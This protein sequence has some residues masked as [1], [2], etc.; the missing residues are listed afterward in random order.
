MIIAIASSALTILLVGGFTY[1]NQR[2]KRRIAIQQTE[3]EKQRADNLMKNQELATIDAMISGQEKERKK[4]AQDLH[5]DLGSS[6]TTIR[7]Y[8]ENLKDHFKAGTSSEIY[9]RTDKLLEDTYKTIR[10]MSHSRHNGVLASKGLI[11]SMETLGKNLTDSGK[12]RVNIYHNGMDR[13]LENSLEL[14]IFRMLQELLNNVVKHAEAS[15]ATINVIGTDTN[16]SLMVEDDGKGFIKTQNKKSNGLG[17][18]SIE[19]R[20]EE[21]GGTFEV[22]SS[23]GNGTTISIEI[24]II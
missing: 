13:K 21:M 17:L 23:P 22:D 11:P 12:L 4:I 24:P 18:Y 5:D 2:K 15:S 19:T 9:M 1:N 6:L 10:E 3:I 8:F 20:I 16:I 7:L 14:N